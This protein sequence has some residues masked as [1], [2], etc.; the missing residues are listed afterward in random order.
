[1]R[2]NRYLYLQFWK[3]ISDAFDSD[4]ACKLIG[5]ESDQFCAFERGLQYAG[6]CQDFGGETLLRFRI[7]SGARGVH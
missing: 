2:A 5:K 4:E 3:M 1:M 6:E 7:D